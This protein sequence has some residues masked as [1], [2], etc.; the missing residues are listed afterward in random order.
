M[1][2]ASMSYDEP[3]VLLPAT[4][5]PEFVK[6]GGDWLCMFNPS[7]RRV[8]DIKQQ[9]VIAHDRQVYSVSFSLDYSRVAVG[10]DSGV[11]LYD[12]HGTDK[13]ELSFSDVGSEERLRENAVR[14]VAFSPDG[15]LL[16]AASDDMKIRVWQLP[17]G[18]LAHTLVGHQR[19]VT[20][21]AFTPD[22]ATI[23]SA[24]GDRT[25]RVWTLPLF[26]DYYSSFY[27][28][29]SDRSSSPEPESLEPDVAADEVECTVLSVE[30]DFTVSATALTSLALSPDGLYAAVGTSGGIIRVWN[31]Q[32]YT[33][34]GQWQAHD[35]EIFTLD[36]G[37]PGLVSGGRDRKLVRW[38]LPPHTLNPFIAPGADAKKVMR[39]E[40]YVLAAATAQ[41]G[42][43]P[44]VA[45]GSRDGRLQMWDP[46]KGELLFCI[47]GHK[48]SI[49]AVDLSQDGT[50]MVSG[51][52]DGEVR[53]WSYTII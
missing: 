29:A 24:S 47:I 28:S 33:P 53:I 38:S 50:L 10:V 14:R 15:T 42:H 6:G 25:L 23:I 39:H 9:A 16:A 1:P 21:L 46:K 32:D 40:E 27:S 51:S 8:M 11:Y 17:S 35:R 5:P 2:I 37:R 36:W 22:S 52:G 26:S 49:T 48:N 31:L 43:V 45:S 7:V 34:I 13:H 18:E 20:S 41:Y 30:A 12:V 44:R 19:E 3:P 4:V